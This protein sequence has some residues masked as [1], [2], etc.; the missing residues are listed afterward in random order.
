MNQ[1]PPPDR[2]NSVSLPSIWKTTTPS[3][4][5]EEQV[6]PRR[7]P[8]Y[9]ARQPQPLSMSPAAHVWLASLPP[10]FQ[11]LAT[12]RRHPHIV[13]RFCEIWR[14][15]VEVAQYFQELLLSNRPDRGGFSFDVLGE[16]VDLQSFCENKPGH[17]R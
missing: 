1:Q 16:L 3:K 17:H 6:R 13:N 8:P 4:L 9:P 10:R 14:Q 15:P 12:A 11:P 5:F 2:P 7:L